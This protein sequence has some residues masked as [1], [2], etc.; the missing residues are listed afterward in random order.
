MQGYEIQQ[1][2]TAQPLVFLLIEDTDHLTGLTGQT[3]TVALSKSGE[4]FAA[5]AGAI[6]EIGDGWYQVAGNATDANTLGP[7]ILHASATGSDP[8]DMLFGVVAYNPLSST[9]LGL[10]YLPAAAPSSGTITAAVVAGMATA[11]VGSVAAGVA[12]ATNGDKTGYALATAPPTAAAVATAVWSADLPGSFTTSQAGN[13]IGVALNTSEASA[14]SAS[15]FTLDPTDPMLGVDLAGWTVLVVGATANAGQVAVIATSNTSTNVQ[16]LAGGEWPGG[17]PTGT[18]AYYLSPPITIAS[19]LDKSGY[20]LATAPPTADAVAT[21]VEA[22][23]A[24]APVGSV[25]SPVTLTAAY[26]SATMLV[27]AVVEGSTGSAVIVSGLPSG[28]SYVGQHL[29]H[30]PSGEARTI[31]TQGY[32]SPNYTFNF[33]GTSGTEA[34]PFSTVE[35][36]DA[37]SPTP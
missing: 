11:P 37:V 36:S 6:T 21:A 14:I 35:T 4:A 29:F 20:S 23:M 1:G 15:G 22:A 17:S 30:Y 28:R 12:V 34:G 3:P 9:N 19:N 24:S 7:L 33:I 5:P 2:Q 8:L 27:G 26:A 13:L 10:S 31:A 18:V 16:T 32:A 25:G